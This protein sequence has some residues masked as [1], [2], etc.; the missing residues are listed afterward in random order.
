M[1]GRGALGVLVKRA[2][3]L[4]GSESS[5]S[6]PRARR[7]WESTGDLLNVKN[8]LQ[9]EFPKLLV[10]NFAWPPSFNVKKEA[11]R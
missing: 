1:G 2:A 4:M 10:A 7:A 9:E 5:F 6:C 3:V 11:P 8:I